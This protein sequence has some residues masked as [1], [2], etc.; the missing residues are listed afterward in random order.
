MRCVVCI[1][2]V[3]IV[4]A[5]PE[6]REG[7]S[8]NTSSTPAAPFWAHSP[9]TRCCAKRPPIQKPG[10]RAGGRAAPPGASARARSLS[11][12]CMPRCSD[13]AA[14]AGGRH[15]RARRR[16]TRLLDGAWK[17]QENTGDSVSLENSTLSRPLGWMALTQHGGDGRARGL[18][19]AREAELLSAIKACLTFKRQPRGASCALLNKANCLRV[20]T[21]QHGLLAR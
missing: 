5:S 3:Y 11:C 12:T 17:S 6:V 15:G 9:E 1:L 21:I 4:Y 2:A 20:H 18:F 14:A 13:S 10:G 19:S 7:S 8:A 16:A